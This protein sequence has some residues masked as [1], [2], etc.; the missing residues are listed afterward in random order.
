MPLP[1]TEIAI[2]DMVDRAMPEAR[3]AT[4]KAHTSSRCI[5]REE[6]ILIVCAVRNARMSG[7]RESDLADEYLNDLERYVKGLS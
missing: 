3:A 2:R 6:G 4:P 5:C 1:A 7:E